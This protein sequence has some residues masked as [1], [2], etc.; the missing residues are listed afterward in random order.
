M[1]QNL[2]LCLTSH[3]VRRINE[4]ITRALLLNGLL[5]IARE[6]YC[7]ERGISLRVN[8]FRENSIQSKSRL[9]RN[10]TFFISNF[11]QNQTFDALKQKS[12]P[13]G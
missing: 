13:D 12:Q 8:P 4:N 6:P 2:F 7:G 10:F 1:D 9:L 3:L 5:A 11:L